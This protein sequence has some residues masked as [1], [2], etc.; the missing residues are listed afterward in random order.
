MISS[1]DKTILTMAF[2]NTF[3]C[4][5]LQTQRSQAKPQLIKF[6]T[7]LQPLWSDLGCQGDQHKMNKRFNETTSIMI[8]SVPDQLM[9]KQTVILTLR[10][11]RRKNQ[12]N[13]LSWIRLL[14]WISHCQ[15]EIIQPRKQVGYSYLIPQL[16]FLWKSSPFL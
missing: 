10:Q 12:H 2:L 15:S 3:I 1:S 11:L 5:Y 16:C 9:W 13:D 4:L 8:M 6:L 14:C 7:S